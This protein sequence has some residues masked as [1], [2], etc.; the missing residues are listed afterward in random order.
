MIILDTNV[1]SESFRPNPNIIV[2]DWFNAQILENLFICSPVLAEIRFGIERLALGAQRRWL[3]QEADRLENHRFSGRILPFDS[4][5]A[6][7]YG[8]IA[9]DRERMGHPIGVADCMIASIALQNGAAVATRDSGGF[10]IPELTVI[11]PF[12]FS[13]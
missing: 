13:K 12:E 9:A 1:I 3:S 6:S 7:I 10:A 11:N 8:R 2:R 4:S 5:A